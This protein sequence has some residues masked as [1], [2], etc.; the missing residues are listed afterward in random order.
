[1]K[2]W[3]ALRGIRHR[4]LRWQGPKPVSNVAALARAARYGLLAR[5]CRLARTEGL[6]LGHQQEDQAET[7]L[8]RL[9]R[10]SGVDGLAA[11]AP[12]SRRDGIDLLRPLLTVPRARLVATLQASGQAW[13]ED[14]SNLD[15]RHARVRLRALLPALAEAGLTPARIAAGAANLARARQALEAATADLAAR[16]LSRT[17]GRVEIDLARLGPAP[18]EIGLRLLDRVLRDIGGRTA[19]RGSTGWSAPMTPS[20]AK[21]P[22]R[23]PF[24]AVSSGGRVIA[25]W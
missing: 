20:W 5:A 24:P 4:T 25:R 12:Q 8:L 21:R 15:P 2:A 10:G 23:G 9:G 3:L 22:E 11:M 18:R 13:I 17:E 1:M 6:L 19:P 7:F 14:P 16:A